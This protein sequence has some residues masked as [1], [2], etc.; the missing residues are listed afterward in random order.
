MQRLV[1][2][3]LLLTRADEGAGGRVRREVDVDDLVA[4]RGGP[5]PRDG[6]GRRHLGG[7]ARGR[8]LGEAVALGQVVRNLLDNAARHADVTDRRARC[9]EDGDGVVL[10]VDDDGA[11]VPDGERER[12]F[13]RFVRLDEARARD[14]GGSGLGLAIVREI[15]W[16]P[17]RRGPSRVPASA[18][19]GSSWTCPRRLTRLPPA[20]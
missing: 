18:A 9:A 5:G 8:V 3:M 6:A 7:S 1:E 10:T 15:A 17:R 19:P 13:E 4:R 16:R 14:D 20:P 2:Q 11:G 12:V